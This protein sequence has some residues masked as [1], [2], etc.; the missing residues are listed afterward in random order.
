MEKCYD[1]G[2]TENL[3]NFTETDVGGR[4]TMSLCPTHLEEREMQQFEQDYCTD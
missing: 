4:K 1:C 3:K 2:A